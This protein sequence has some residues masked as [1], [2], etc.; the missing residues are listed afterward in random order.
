MAWYDRV[1]IYAVWAVVVGVI[2]PALTILVFL[3]IREYIRTSGSHAEWPEW[4]WQYRR[5]SS[6]VDHLGLDA[7]SSNSVDAP[8]DA[9][10]GGG[11]D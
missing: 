3:L 6:A 9:V 10:G 2:I 8:A 11:A 7:A 5:T 1:V 4:Y